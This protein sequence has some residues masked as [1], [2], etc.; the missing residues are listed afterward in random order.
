VPRR[1]AESCEAELDVGEIAGSD[2]VDEVITDGT[3]NLR[4]LDYS[5]GLRG[6]CCS[7]CFVAR[8][9]VR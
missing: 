7:A 2:W 8:V 9:E 3:E 6:S 4:T 1:S 5:G